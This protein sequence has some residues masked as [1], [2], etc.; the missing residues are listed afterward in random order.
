MTNF[1]SSFEVLPDDIKDLIYSKII[2]KQ[3]SC[4]MEEI[5]KYGLIRSWLYYLKFIENENL[6]SMIIDLAVIYLALEEFTDPTSVDPRELSLHSFELL[7]QY[8]ILIDDINIIKN[9]NVWYREDKIKKELINVIKFLMMKIDIYYIQKVI[10][11]FLDDVI[12]NELEDI[13]E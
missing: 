11:P 6:S 13:Y 5:R 2:Y 1:I 7:E 3:N 10:Q 12:I 4:L 8:Y 9:N